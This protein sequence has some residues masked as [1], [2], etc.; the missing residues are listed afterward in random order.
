MDSLVHIK[1]I[2]SVDHWIVAGKEGKK[3]VAIVPIPFKPLTK[4]RQSR[5]PAKY[6]C[7]SEKNCGYYFNT[8]IAESDIQSLIISVIRKDMC[9]R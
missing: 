4:S 2:S 1:V 3:H 5:I 8:S 6:L 7:S 9:M